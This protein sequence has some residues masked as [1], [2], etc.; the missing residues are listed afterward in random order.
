MISASATE[1]VLI[2][3]KYRL[4]RLIGESA[5]SRIFEAV[6]TTLDRRLALR[7]FRPV[8]APGHRQS[9]LAE[10]R[11]CSRLAHPN[12]LAVYELGEDDGPVVAMELLEG[13]TLRA[14]L[15][16]S[17]PLPLAHVARIGSG[18][19]GALSVAHERGARHPALTPANVFMAS[20][21]D[22]PNAKLSD[23]DEAKEDDLRADLQAAGAVIYETLTGVLPYCD[24]STAASS[25]L[26]VGP[27]EVR[28]DVGLDADAFTMRALAGHLSERFQTAEEML[29]AWASIE[30]FEAHLK[31]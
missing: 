21:R 17:R 14:L 7:R 28:D 5:H 26:P 15:S 18:I 11:I 23:F 20:M 4:E 9:V 2:A 29:D 16:R 19:L 27:S 24:G 8:A 31:T 13:E 1:G 22:G 25:R 3:G 6:Q 30:A 10:A 12:V